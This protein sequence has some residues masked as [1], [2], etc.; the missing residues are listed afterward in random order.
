MAARTVDGPTDDWLTM[1][2]LAKLLR[3]SETTIRRRIHDGR[4][5]DAGRVGPQGRFWS[6]EVVVWWRWTVNWGLADPQ[7]APT[8]DQLE[9]SSADEPEGS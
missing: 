3:L 4:F 9:P 1:A 7:P 5:P 8:T 6:W 2:E